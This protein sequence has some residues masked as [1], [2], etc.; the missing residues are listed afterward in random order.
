MDNIMMVSKKEKEDTVLQLDLMK[1]NVVDDSMTDLEDACQ[2][3]LIETST[4]AV[5]VHLNL[6]DFGEFKYKVQST[7]FCQYSPYTGWHLKRN[8]VMNIKI[9][10]SLKL[11]DPVI[12]RAILIRRNPVYRMY[13]VDQVCEKHREKMC[14]PADRVHVLQAA[15][16]SP[17]WYYDDEGPRK[18]LCF[19]IG[20]P[21]S[22]FLATT[23][24]LKCVCNDTC[25]TTMDPSFTATEASRDLMLV[26]TLESKTF[27]MVVAR[28]SLMVWPKAAICDRDMRK[29]QRRKA[30]GG[31]AVAET[32]K[33]I[34][35]EK[36]NLQPRPSTR[37]LV[38]V[39]K[40][41]PTLAVAKL[42]PPCDEILEEGSEDTLVELVE[43]TTDEKIRKVFDSSSDSE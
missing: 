40:E 26:L 6:E 19:E 9:I 36:I 7:R 27:K 14:S 11:S 1:N 21:N 35:T 34:N 20:I 24:G 43:E 37:L 13:T 38:D 4:Q 18:S 22:G 29:L 3:G 41:E 33:R 42:Y 12:V 2:G 32:R 28:R 23:I 25:V 8:E 10:N 30:K 17:D 16:G 39:A 31:A 5:A 15:P